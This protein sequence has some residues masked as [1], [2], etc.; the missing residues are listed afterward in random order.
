MHHVSRKALRKGLT[1]VEMP[2]LEE[3]RALCAVSWC[4]CEWLCERLC[5]MLCERLCERLCDGLQ[6]RFHSGHQSPGNGEFKYDT[7]IHLHT[8]IYIYWYIYMVSSRLISKSKIPGKFLKLSVLPYNQANK[9]ILWTS[10]FRKR[11][12]WGKLRGNWFWCFGCA[13]CYEFWVSLWDSAHNYV[14]MNMF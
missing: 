14:Y 5:G 4:A 3:L 13:L 11:W 9:Y 10:S 6:L 12:I 7:F 2:R 1:R 8:Y